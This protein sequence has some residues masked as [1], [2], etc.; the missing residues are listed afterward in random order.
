MVVPFYTA[1]YVEV[2]GS[3]LG[4][5]WI[6]CGLTA[7]AFT[8]LGSLL[9]QHGYVERETPLV[10]V[11]FWQDLATDGSWW[12]ANKEPAEKP[13]YCGMSFVSETD[14]GTW[15][16][17]AIGC[18]RPADIKGTLVYP[19]SN[20][21]SVAL[22]VAF[23]SDPQYNSSKVYIYEGMENTTLALQIS[24]S[25][26]RETVSH[27]PFCQALG[28]VSELHPLGLPLR[29]RYEE[30]HPQQG[31]GQGFLLLSVDD[32]VQATGN[33]LNATG[34]EGAPLQLA[35]LE[36]LAHVDIR[37]YHTPYR[38]PLANWN[39]LRLQ[40][41]NRL[42]CTVRFT[43][44]RNLFTPIKWFHEGINPVALQ[45]GLRLTA[46]GTGSIGYFSSAELLEKLLIGFA[47]FSLSQAILDLAWYYLHPKATVIA[48]QAYHPLE[49]RGP[50]SEHTVQEKDKN[51]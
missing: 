32:V 14:G 41:A 47:A 1:C 15:G 36:V 19:T 43:M 44:L 8:L 24:Y 30:L 26:S 40:Q 11:A 10:N 22:S 29:S 28:R 34:S 35:G 21:V 48:A 5:V 25:T 33:D 31:Y 7:V 45:H 49:L 50:A 37:N 39:P 20:E 3:R 42:D 13:S 12:P 46:L 9:G 2:H 16:S 38:W 27:L 18:I 23:G 17:E 6:L 51:A 4:C